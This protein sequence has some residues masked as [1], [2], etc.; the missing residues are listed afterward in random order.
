[1]DRDIQASITHE[2][3]NR[4]LGW[5]VTEPLSPALLIVNHIVIEDHVIK[6]RETSVA[7]SI[8]RTGVDG[9]A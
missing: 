1:M 2:K 7:V 6:S 4:V 9:L 5:P 3:E 8:S